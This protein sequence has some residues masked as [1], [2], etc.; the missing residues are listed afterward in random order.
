[1]GTPRDAP[2]EQIVVAAFGRFPVAL[3]HARRELEHRLGPVALESPPFAFDQ[4][5]YYEATMGQGLVKQLWT[6]GQLVPPDCLPV[7]KTLTNGLERA[8]ADGGRFDAERPVNLDPGLL[9]L[10][11][12]VLATT[13]DQAHRVYLRDG[14]FAEVTLQYRDGSWQPC[15]WTYADYRL[16]VVADF[17][18]EAR[19]D[20]KRR[21]AAWTEAA[22]D[23]LAA[24]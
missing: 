13:K 6:F 11:K 14:I 7:L 18:L 9:G 10:A 3:D 12:L 21:L 1:V 8:L 24:T 22:E 15:P 2:P 17:L 5:R 16:P 20:Y 19:A 4:T 23:V